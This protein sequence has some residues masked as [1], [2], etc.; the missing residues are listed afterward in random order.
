MELNEDQK[1]AVTKWVEEG[2]SLAEIQRRLS[3]DFKMDMTYMDVRF[4]VLDLGLEV[5]DK[6]DSLASGS[7]QQNSTTDIFSEE[8]IH[9]QLDGRAKFGVSVTI[10]KVIKPGSIVSGGVTF[11]DGVSARWMLDQI[12][13]LAID[14][15][16]SG[17]KPSEED[18][19]SFQD[20][21]RNVLQTHGY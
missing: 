9:E 10:D 13:R 16:R 15:G 17:Y 12:G 6:G 14:A 2:L 11:S 5:K 8:D 7:N 18:L 1:S 3:S 21:L 4:L 19:Q 20:E